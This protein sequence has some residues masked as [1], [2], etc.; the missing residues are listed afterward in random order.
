MVGQNLEPGREDKCFP[1]GLGSS[2]SGHCAAPVW[3][4][5]RKTLAGF[6]PAKSQDPS[7]SVTSSAGDARY[8]SQ[9]IIITHGGILPLQGADIVF[10][11]E[12][13][14]IGLQGALIVE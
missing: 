10:V 12:K 2:L 14:H 3:M 13:I 6:K 8:D 7:L 1:F 11:Q 9:S 5:T 4:S